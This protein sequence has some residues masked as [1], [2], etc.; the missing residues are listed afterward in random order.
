M[1]VFSKYPNK[2]Y[3][4]TGTCTGGSVMKALEA[5]FSVI[6]SVEL[7]DYFYE[8]SSKQFL[9]NDRVKL[10]HGD[11]T[12]MLWDMIEDINEPITFFL[13]GH[14]SGGKTANNGTGVPE[15]L[16]ELEQIA[17]HPIK[18]HTILIDDYSGYSPLNLQGIMK[19]INPD[20]KFAFDTYQELYPGD[21]LTATL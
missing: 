15:L 9:G 19:E 4:E 13:D 20:Y 3:V 10:Y 5:G 2:Y 6:R 17:R 14:P 8:Y 11:S 12:L 18:T 7:S 1:N 21:M 16:K